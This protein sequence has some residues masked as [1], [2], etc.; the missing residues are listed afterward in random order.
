MRLPFP[1]TLKF[2]PIVTD[3][4][5]DIRAAKDR[6]MSAILHLVHH[7]GFPEYC[8]IHAYHLICGESLYVCD[9]IIVV[10]E[11]RDQEGKDMRYFSSMAKLMHIKRDN[12]SALFTSWEKANGADSALRC[13]KSAARAPLANRWGRSGAM[14]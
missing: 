12:G 14:E 8:F 5:S 9:E 11:V 3:D 6:V 1:V 13:A 7:L 4:G 10:L 2:W